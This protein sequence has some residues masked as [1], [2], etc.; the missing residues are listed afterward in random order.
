MR[1]RPL[2]YIGFGL[3]IILWILNFIALAFY[4]YWTIGWYDYL[5]HFLGGLTL[6]VL[7]VWAFKIERSSLKSFLAVFT[8]VMVAG[9]V[10]EVLEYINDAAFSTEGYVLDTTK[11]LIMDAVGA[12]VAYWRATSPPR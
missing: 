10:W 1:R 7:A 5:M 2:L 8:I 6:G 11:D 9:G 3:A 12:A 4:F